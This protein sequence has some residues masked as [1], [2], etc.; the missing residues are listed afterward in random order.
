[1]TTDEDSK[2]VDRPRIE[3]ITFDFTG[4]LAHCPGLALAYREVLGRHGVEASE[5]DLAERIPVLWRELGCLGELHRDRFSVHGGSRGFW[6]R[7]LARLSLELGASHEPSRFASA[8]LFAR[9]G[10]AEAW[11]LY[12]DVLPVLRS[13]RR[14]GLR[15]GIVS[16]WDHRLP[17][18]L[19]GLGVGALVDAVVYSEDLGLEKPHPD[20]FS[21][22]LGQL[23]VLPDRALHVGN[24]PVLDVEGATAVGMAALLVDRRQADGQLDRLLQPWLEPLPDQ[25]G[26]EASD[27]PRRETPKT[28]RIVAFPS[29]AQAGTAPV[30]GPRRR[31]R[32]PT[33][34]EGLPL[35]GVVLAGGRSSRMGRDKASIPLPDQAATLG[36]LAIERLA[37]VVERVVVA[38]AGKDRSWGPAWPSV[39]DGPGEGPMAGILGAAAANPDHRLLVLGCDLPAVPPSLLAALA[40]SRSALA[41]PTTERGPE[42]LCAAYGPRALERL[43]AMAESG[44]YALHRLLDASD[45]LEPE[46]FERE[47]LQAFGDP[48]RIFLNLNRPADLRTWLARRAERGED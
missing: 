21:R 46:L 7:F 33:G 22:C 34:A 47:R 48:D 15:L 26:P 24:H 23:G 32:A 31:A 5:K 12:P 3:A 20:L 8:E 37:Q 25:A 19:D 45:E 28:P 6:H 39:E 30:S 10:R 1:M 29:P 11:A 43:L 41:I 44:M 17:G 4:T 42:P 35:L 14:R 16:N 13:A 9:L 36:D 40:A 38:D 27:R 2:A 18:L